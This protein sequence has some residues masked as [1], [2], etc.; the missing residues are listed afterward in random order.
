MPAHDFL[1][2]TEAGWKLTWQ[3][4][5][6]RL[7]SSLSVEQVSR[8]LDVPVKSAKRV[9]LSLFSFLMNMKCLKL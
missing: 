9:I 6:S 2:M 1:S 7:V 5:F 4:T 3:P 8:T